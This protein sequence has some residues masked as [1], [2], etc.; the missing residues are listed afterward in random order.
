M[1]DSTEEEA[2]MLTEPRD[3]IVVSGAQRISTVR[4]PERALAEA[5]GAAKALTR[6]LESK[7][8]AVI[9]NGKQYLEFPDWQT[10]G[11]F[12]GVTARVV[13]TQFVSLDT[14][15]NDTG[16]DS[17]FVTGWEASADAIGPDG[18]VLSSADGMCMTDEEKW[19][20]RNRYEWC[21]LLK[22]K[23]RHDDASYVVEDPGTGNMVWEKQGDKNRPVKKRML[24]GS[25]PVPTFQLRSMAQTRACAKA[26]R[27]VLSWV[28]VLGGY[29]T[30]PAEELDDIPDKQDPSEGTTIASVKPFKSDEKQYW[31]IQCGNDAVRV[32]DE[33]DIAD[34]ASEFM[35]SG[36]NVQFRCVDRQIKGKAIDW[37]TDVTEV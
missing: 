24:V 27:N 21:Y 19:G 36:T 2:V 29:G 1:D 34:A 33:P 31:A 14:G 9:M 32:T 17:T 6:V 7:K 35:A 26:L 11:H 23:D 25:A 10:V 15:H 16:T 30:T 13:K 3:G 5:I 22:G 8:D 20:A 4:D 18:Q 12:Y 37:I 28:A